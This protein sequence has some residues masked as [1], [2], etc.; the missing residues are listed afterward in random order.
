MDNNQQMSQIFFLTEN[1]FAFV[2]VIVFVVVVDED[3]DDGFLM[4]LVSSSHSLYAEALE[5]EL[6]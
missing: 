4:K 6:V 5:A 3:D 2:F 1:N